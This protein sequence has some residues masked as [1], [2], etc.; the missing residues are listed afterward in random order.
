MEIQEQEQ[1]EEG[2]DYLLGCH[3]LSLLWKVGNEEVEQ[4]EFQDAKEGRREEGCCVSCYIVFDTSSL[5]TPYTPLPR[6]SLTSTSTSSAL[7]RTSRSSES[8]PSSPVPPTE[9]ARLTP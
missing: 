3:L 2:D 6:S 7:A 1:D 9:L 5:L 8:G 4:E